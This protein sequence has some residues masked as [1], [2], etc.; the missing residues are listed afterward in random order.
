ML[1]SKESYLIGRLLKRLHPEI[2]T[3]IIEQYIRPSEDPCDFSQIPDIFDKFCLLN[4]ISP[5][6]I[7]GPLEKRAQFDNRKL[8]I[9]VM[10]RIFNPQIHHHPQDAIILR[11]GFNSQIS[12]F[13]GI[14]QY[15][16]TKTI[17]IAI[18]HERVYEEYRERVDEI[19][20]KL[21]AL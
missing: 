4:E 7:K 11:P 13:L 14:G 6:D 10:I 1:K 8:F 15:V 16:T 12:T 3:S 17:R 20:T 19:T 5:K 2:A 18:V 21:K 9:S